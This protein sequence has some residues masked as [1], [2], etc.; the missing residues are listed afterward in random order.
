MTTSQAVTFLLT[1][2]TW[3]PRADRRTL[4]SEFHQCRTKT[5]LPS[6]TIPVVVPH[7]IPCT[8][9]GVFPPPALGAARAQQLG[10]HFQ[11][12]KYH[13]Q[14][15]QSCIFLYSYYISDCCRH[16]KRTSSLWREAQ[17]H[18]SDRAK[19]RDHK[20]PPASGSR[21]DNLQ[22]MHLSEQVAGPLRFPGRGLCLVQLSC[23][24]G[25]GDVHAASSHDQLP[26]DLQRFT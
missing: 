24:T 15:T 18:Q 6:N 20:L 26:K 14:Y 10:F 1:A 16:C 13:T 12:C 19:D 4:Q 3:A 2:L 25:W 21:G 7:H 8:S 22:L 11:L 5:I 17:P 23:S 9:P